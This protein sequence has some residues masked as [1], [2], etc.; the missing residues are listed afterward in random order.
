MYI[1]YLEITVDFKVIFKV[2]KT[3]NKGM[4]TNETIY[5]CDYWLYV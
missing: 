1:L 2:L 3:R 4:Q 5:N